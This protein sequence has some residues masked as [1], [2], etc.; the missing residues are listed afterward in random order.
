MLKER[1]MLKEKD[2]KFGN[3]FFYMDSGS[4]K[5]YLVEIIRLAMKQTYREFGF[6]KKYFAKDFS[7]GRFGGKEIFWEEGFEEKR[8]IGG[9][10]YGD[11]RQIF[12]LPGAKLDHVM[13]LRVEVMFS[14]DSTREVNQKYLFHCPEEA[15]KFWQAELGLRR[16]PYW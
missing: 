2:I 14:N 1:K 11:E 16:W 8:N 10:M 15:E 7:N 9:I 4:K 12:L 13:Y 5:P 3:H 6:Y